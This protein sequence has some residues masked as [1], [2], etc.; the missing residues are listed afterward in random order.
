MTPD[1]PKAPAAT[2][3]TPPPA[4]PPPK[5]RHRARRWILGLLLTL[6]LLLLLIVGLAWYGVSTER[7]TGILL[8]RVAGMLPGELTVGSQKGPL[9]GPLELRDVRYR[10]EA[11]DVRL[12]RV[13]LDWDAGKLRRRQVDI[14][15]LH[16]NGIR[17][18]LPP[19]KE[20][21]ETKDG[22]LVDI[23]LPVNI[24]VRDALIRDVEIIRAGAAPFRL[25]EIA[26]DGRTK[27]M[28]DTLQVRNLRVVGPIFNLQAQGELTPVGAYD[29]DLQVKATYDPPEYPPFVVNADLD[30]T[31]E[32]LG[33]TANLAQPFDAQVRGHVLTPMRELGLDLAAQVRNFDAREIN[34][35]WPL[36]RISEGNVN[37]KGQLDNFTSQ[38]TVAGAFEDYG[39]GVADYRLAR[40]G[41]DFFFEY[42]NLKTDSGVQLGAKGTVSTAGEDIALDVAADWQRFRWPLTG[43]APVVVSRAGEATLRGTLKD[44]EV[45]VNADLAGPN[46]PPGRWA[47]AGK[48]TQEKMTIR[49]LRGDVLRGRL[50]ANGVVSWKPQVTWNVKLNGDGLDPGAQWREW[51]G[52]VAFSAASDGVLR[53][54]GPYGKVNLL[55]LD[56]NLRGNP[57]AGR[58][59]LELAGERY[60]LPRLD[61]RSGSA[62]LTAAGAFTKDR[63]DIDWRL[64][65]PNL[66]EA[67]PDAGGAVTAQGNLTGPWTSPRVRAQ[68]DGQSIVFRTYNVQTLALVADVDLASNGPMLIDLDATNV[69]VDER[70][71]DTVTL[72]GRGTRRAHEI[73]LAVRAPEGN[74][75]FAL[76]GGLQGT[77]TWSGEI[78]RLDLANEQTGTWTLAGPAALT[79]GATRAAL[80]NFCWTSAEN[81]GARLCAE[82]QWSKTGPWSANGNIAGLPFDLFKPFLPPDLEI[83]GAV[84]GTFQGQGTTAGFV[85]AAVDIRPG[86]GE[87]RYPAES[88][89]TVTVRYEQGSVVVNAGANG[90]TGSAA[91]TFVDTGTIQANLALPQYNKIG[92]PLQQQSLNGRIQANFSN[93]GLVEAFVPDLNNTRGVLQADLTLGGTVANPSVAGAAELLRA[94]V[95]VPKFGLEVRQIELTARADGQG[96]L[97]LRGSARSGNG[98]VNIGGAVALD[99]QPSRLTIQGRNFLAS[100]TREARVLVSP[101]IVV[102]MNGPR[103]DV[104]G[105]VTIPEAKIEQEGKRERAAIPVSQDVYFVPASEEAEDAAAQQRQLYARVRVILGEKVNV[106]VQGFSGRPTGSLLVIEEPGKATT[107]VGELEVQ[108]GIYKAY[109]QDLTLERGRVIF[110]GGPIDNPGLD[111]RAYRRSRD[112]DDLAGVNIRGTL[113]SPQATLYSDPPMPESDTLAVLLTGRRLGEG[114]QQ[115]ADL[116]ANAANTLGLKGGNLIAKKIA[117]RYGL[118]EARVETT[119]GLE[120][121]SLVVGKYLSPRLY[122]TYGIGLF[123]PINTFRIRYILGREWTLQAEQGEGTS[124]D[125][126]YTVERGKGGEAPVPKRDKG[127]SV[128]PAAGTTT[129]G[130]TG[131][132]GAR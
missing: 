55:E 37:I 74:L 32:R 16:A 4:A 128:D 112:G 17:V 1:E 67:L 82:G 127:E 71:F 15:R 72:D 61:L 45:D 124:A 117:A 78:R 62:R 126:L 39:S 121:A 109:G 64:A 116:V 101:D 9:T 43:G 105:D 92:A 89:E 65:A 50:T 110:A 98:T 93:L 2:P 83:T 81:N 58:V 88:G 11:M 63:G 26:L 19:A 129:E 94:Q 69:G 115:D 85:T 46:I 79:A 59:Y 29:V 114:S 44:Y 35:E 34:P 54:A 14:Q 97:Q 73:A 106:K 77:T 47:L 28:S 95:D 66:G 33:V 6:L 5:K 3:E 20:E 56:G 113:R 23:H 80:R 96:P 24:I 13:F 8:S 125:I 27:P 41:E 38:G 42:L 36:A 25:D 75:D 18:V 48:G 31:L 131:G 90:L 84:N 91:M 107:A 120:E 70:R 123:E 51:P 104:T 108:D 119:G 76:S 132:G 99:G 111:L 22:R 130:T 57:L 49:S 100:D 122:V 30:G 53:D 12:Q 118:E 103:I 10:T 40:R 86:P 21:D 102:A 68:A 52:R 60:R 7:G 87:I